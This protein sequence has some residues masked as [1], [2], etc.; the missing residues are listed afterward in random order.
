MP[1]SKTEIEYLE[2]AKKLKID[3]SD[4]KKRVLKK[5]IAYAAFH[6]AYKKAL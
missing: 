2:R 5:R 1:M 4:I 3:F 6:N